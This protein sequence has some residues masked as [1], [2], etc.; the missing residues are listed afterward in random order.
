MHHSQ[1]LLP[2]GACAGPA[3]AGAVDARLHATASHPNDVYIFLIELGALDTPRI[4][5]HSPHAGVTAFQ[6]QTSHTSLFPHCQRAYN[7]S[8]TKRT[9]R[10]VG[11]M[12]APSTS[13][14]LKCGLPI[15]G[16]VLATCREK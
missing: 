2:G 14:E 7:Q 11:T 3:R 5:M 13:S 4:L 1:Y 10:Y 12:L 9:Q 6:I 15:L 16:H 8:I